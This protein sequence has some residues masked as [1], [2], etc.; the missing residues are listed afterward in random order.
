MKNLTPRSLV[1]SVFFLLLLAVPVYWLVIGRQTDKKSLAEDRRLDAFPLLELNDFSRALKL[2]AVGNF[3]EA[4]ET[5]FNQF[6]NRSFQRKYEGAASDQFPLRFPGIVTVKAVERAQIWLAYALLPD[7]VIPTDM[8]SNLYVMR[9]GSMML[10]SPFPYNEESRRLI[11]DKISFYKKLIAKNPDLHF[12]AFYAERLENAPYNP[13]NNTFPGSDGGRNYEYFQ[14]HLPAGLTL[15]TLSFKDFDEY[16]QDNYRSDHHWN[17]YGALRAYAIIYDMLAE[18]FPQ[19]SE[20]LD[21]SRTYTF[22]DIGFSGSFAGRTL[23]PIQPDEFSVAYV[24]LPPYQVFIDGSEVKVDAEERYAAGNYRRARYAHHYNN[25]FGTGRPGTLYEYIFDNNS[26]RNLLIIGN[27]FKWPIYPL[28]A[29]HYHQT[30]TV[31]LLEHENFQ[32]NKFLQEHQVDDVLI[33]GDADA[34]FLPIH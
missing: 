24:D 20:H 13:L 16:K 29:Y 27:S 7:R 14:A 28:L 18:G 1:L 19:I 25:Y 4:G 23:Y 26:P 5:F 33:L 6:I 32:V 31:N 12:Y 34:V 11:D 15:S 8:V 22:P 30:W 21:T 17:I 3:K 2:S 10:S 9:D